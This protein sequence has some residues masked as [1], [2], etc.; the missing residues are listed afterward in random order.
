[1]S[2]CLWDSESFAM[3]EYNVGLYTH[4]CNFRQLKNCEIHLLEYRLTLSSARLVYSHGK[5]LCLQYP[6]MV[7]IREFVRIIL[8]WFDQGPV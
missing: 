4:R 7:I 8:R 6:L 3:S 1:M 2:I 5:R